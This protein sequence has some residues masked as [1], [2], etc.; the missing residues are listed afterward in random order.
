MTSAV[1]PQQ[2]DPRC[3]FKFFLLKHRKVYQIENNDKLTLLFEIPRRQK[4]IVLDTSVK[5]A[6]LGYNGAVLFY[7]DINVFGETTFLKYLVHSQEELQE[8]LTIAGAK[9]FGKRSVTRLLQTIK[10]SFRL[11]RLSNF[12]ALEQYLHKK[13]II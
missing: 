13:N 8:L 10:V 1:L 7:K 5:L 11:S 3:T 6:A 2:Q 9:R 4:H 12:D